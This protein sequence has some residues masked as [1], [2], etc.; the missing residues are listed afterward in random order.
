MLSASPSRSV[1]H[2]GQSVLRVAVFVC[3]GG[4]RAGAGSVSGGV[5]CEVIVVAVGC[6]AGGA[7]CRVC[8]WVGGWGMRG[9]MGEGMG[10]G[11]EAGRGG[12]GGAHS[13]PQ[14]TTLPPRLRMRLFTT[15][16]LVLSHLLWEA[17]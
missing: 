4:V 12:A 17:K 15:C 2:C 6:M 1:Q 10:R 14:P 3:G 11:G 7:R 5:H 16:A 8:G 13:P 9:D